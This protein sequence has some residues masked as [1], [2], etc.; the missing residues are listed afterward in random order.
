MIVVCICMVYSIAIL[1]WSRGESYYNYLD[2]WGARKLKLSR[3]RISEWGLGDEGIGYWK[4][5]EMREEICDLRGMRWTPP[6]IAGH[7]RR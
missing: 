6:V 4:M 2:T 7:D 1:A 3:C 5:R